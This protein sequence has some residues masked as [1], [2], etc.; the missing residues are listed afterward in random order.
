VWP[1]PVLGLALGLT[2]L[3]VDAMRFEGV[4]AFIYYQF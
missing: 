2:I 3:I 4:A 1:A